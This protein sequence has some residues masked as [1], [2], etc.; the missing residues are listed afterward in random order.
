MDKVM[1]KKERRK[2][3]PN[4]EV[5]K[6]VQLQYILRSSGDFAIR[7]HKAFIEEGIDSKVIGLFSHTEETARIKSMTPSKRLK[8]RIDNHLQAYLSRGVNKDMGLFSYPI[9]GN[10]VAQLPEIQAAD[11]IYVHWVLNGFMNFNSLHQL[12]RL[13]KPIIFIMHDMWNMTG[14][15]HHSFDCEKY[16]SGC[17]QCPMLPKKSFKD[18]AATVFKKKRKFYKKYD[19]LYFVSPSSWLY[20]CARSSELL[21]SK[22]VLHIPNILER[23]I[24]KPFDKTT[25]RQILNIPSED[26]T[27]AF[28][29]VSLTSPYKGWSYLKQALR[30][31]PDYI[32]PN[33]VTV[34]IFG[35]QQNDAIADAIPFKTHF[36][37][38]LHD[39]YTVATVYNAAD[40]FIAPSLADNLPYTVFEALSCGTP[41]V[42]FDI[43]GIPDMIKHKKNGYLATYKDADDIAKGVHYCLDKKIEGF[44]P[45]ELDSDKS[46]ARHIELIE[47]AKAAS[48]A[49]Q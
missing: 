4:S 10:N 16:K 13:N 24:F 34:L 6:V 19:H 48:D 25:A 29:A 11:V 38:R 49:I 26:I 7:L 2:K 41:V 27:I 43:G 35:G 30:A 21:R 32:N 31:L 1:P 28:G 8:S 20:D 39:E 9:L 45:A 33:E 47:K 15:C 17:Q 46:I 22:P 12:A 40:V 14:G 44:V 37:G 3:A 5:R 18:M 23:S 36:L 42:A